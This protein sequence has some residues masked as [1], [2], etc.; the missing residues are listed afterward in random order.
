MKKTIPFLAETAL[1][2]HGLTAISNEEILKRIPQEFPWLVW[3]DQGEIVVGDAAAFLPFRERA[4]E[5]VRID[6]NMLATA[7]ERKISG[8]LTAS[9][10]MAVA[11]QRGV[12]IAVT[13]GMGGIAN[14]EGG[15]ICNDLTA[16]ASLPVT[17]I[18]TSPKDMLNIRATMEWLNAHNVTV[19]GYNREICDGYV[20][21][22]EA[23]QLSGKY[24]GQVLTKKGLL[25]LNCIACEKRINNREILTQALAK[26]VEAKEKGL[27]F[28]PAVNAAL[29]EATG[30]KSGE[31]QF[32][33]FIDNMY[34]ANRISKNGMQ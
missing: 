1:L 9:G 34:L 24:T 14:P 33:S 28:H 8:A 6:Q 16:L 15:S 17:L 29:A 7:C 2:T 11:A 19:L 4:G 10:T 20:F 13:A 25:I 26:G 30:G 18:A 12:A 3:V 23:V 32:Q 22:G 27:F 21:R 31:I 5:L